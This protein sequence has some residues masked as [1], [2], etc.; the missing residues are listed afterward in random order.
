MAILWQET[1]DGTLYQV[2]SAGKT[3]RLYTDNVLHSQYNPAKKL[4][5][6]VWDLLF[7]PALAKK[8]DNPIRVLVLGVGGGAVIHM[9]NEFLPC[10]KI[11]GI[12]LNPTHIEI[13]QNFFSLS[14]ENIELIEADAIRWVEN[15]KEKFDIIIDDLFYEEDDEP[16]KVASPNATWF[17]N[18]YSLLKPKGLIIM[19]FVARHTAMTAA[20]LYDDYVAKL[21]PN[22][23]HFTTPHYDNHVLAFSKN[24]L[25]A[26]SIR[27]AIDQHEDLK[28]LKKHLRFSCR[29]L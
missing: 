28:L 21:L 11:I 29:T 10:E 18:L 1:R 26:K 5:G 4:T 22:T 27:Q 9:L 24:E 13:A 14:S 8:M 16:V 2:R 7:L 23:L 19:N 15:S 25:N 20:P 3:L 12:E 6:S 17:Y